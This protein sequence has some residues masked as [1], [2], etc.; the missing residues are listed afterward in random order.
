MRELVLVPS[1]I[2]A[3]ASLP[4]SSADIVR[5]EMFYAMNLSRLSATGRVSRPH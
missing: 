5:A 4:A 1:K 3:Q 2:V